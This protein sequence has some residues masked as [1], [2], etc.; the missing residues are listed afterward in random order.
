M[1]VDFDW[2]TASA[3]AYVEAYRRAISLR[4]AMPAPRGAAAR[5]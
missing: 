2:R 3:P 5:R 4:R 1:A